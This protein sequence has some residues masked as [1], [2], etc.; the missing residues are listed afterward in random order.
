MFVNFS[1][2]S[3][4]NGLLQKK[5]FCIIYNFKLLW[6]QVQMSDDVDIFLFDMVD[7]KKTPVPFFG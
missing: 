6:V 3:I 1:K 5:C 2:G 4:V 7:R